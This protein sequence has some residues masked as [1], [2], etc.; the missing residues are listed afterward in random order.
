[1]MAL[2]ILSM[3]RVLVMIIIVP[4]A[5]RQVDSVRQHL[6]EAFNN[7][8]L[9]IS[10]KYCVENSTPSE[11]C[12]SQAKLSRIS[13]SCRYQAGFQGDNEASFQAGHQAGFR[14]GP[15]TLFKCQQVLQ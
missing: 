5:L 12:I 10:Q 1:M 13:L 4:E 9:F 7:S 2:V 11:V 3:M 14:V 6:C 15:D 8:Q